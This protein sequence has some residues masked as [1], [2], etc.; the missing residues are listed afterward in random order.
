MHNNNKN[1]IMLR[2]YFQ[3]E[4]KSTNHVEKQGKEKKSNSY[5]R[6]SQCFCEEKRQIG[7]R[8][9]LC[10]ACTCQ[11]NSHLKMNR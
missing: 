4:T 8:K 2:L 5:L 10:M 3:Y 7:G 6:K 1:V 11:N 9:V